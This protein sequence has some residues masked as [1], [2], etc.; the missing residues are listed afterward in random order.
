MKRDKLFI[1]KTPF[2]DTAYPGQDFYCWNCILMEGL[3]KMFPKLEARMDV[4]R[5]DFLRPRE[6]VIEHVGEENQS[7][8]TLVLADNAPKGIETGE[9]KNTRFVKGKDAIMQALNARHGIPIP[10]P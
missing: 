10:H 1:L 4:E 2:K 9:Y 5:I 3:L 6:S 7:L 8:P